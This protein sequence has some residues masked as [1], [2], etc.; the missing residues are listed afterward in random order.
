MR[1]TTRRLLFALALVFAFAVIWRKVRIVLW[2]HV[3]FWQLL[4]LFLVLAIAIYLVF[5]LLLGRSDR[6]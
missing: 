5:E 6:Y 3:G 1:R 4:I 2:V